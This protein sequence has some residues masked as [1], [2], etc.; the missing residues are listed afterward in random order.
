MKFNKNCC[1]CADFLKEVRALFMHFIFPGKDNME[2]LYYIFI[3]IIVIV[4]IA[5]IILCC[6][7]RTRIKQFIKSG[8]SKGKYNAL[9]VMF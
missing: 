6:L 9:N 3:V 7:H 4:I 1:L 5:I 2:W 8:T